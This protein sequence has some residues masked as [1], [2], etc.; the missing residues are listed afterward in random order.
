MQK[1]S[2]NIENFYEGTL[3]SKDK[4]SP[5]YISI[6]NPKFIE[7]DGTYNAGILVIDYYREISDLLLKN[8][9]NTN[10][11]MNISMFYE[12]QDTYQ[13]IKDLTYC[14]IFI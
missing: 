6:K 2:D 4:I 14:C 5:S 3:S 11:N 10:V 7:I 1:E 12:K 8:I 9:I 13:T